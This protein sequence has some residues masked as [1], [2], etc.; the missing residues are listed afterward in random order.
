MLRHL[1]PQIALAS[2]GLVIVGLLLFAVSRQAFGL[3]PARGG[4]LVEAVVGPP[5][6]FNPI[7]ALSDT[8][9]D[10]ARLVFSGLTRVDP[11]GKVLPDLA[12]R[13]S[14]SSDGRVYTFKLRPGV[15][16][17]D[18][19][20]LTAE[21]VVFTASLAAARIPQKAPLA[22]TWEKAR[23]TAVDE[24]TV[25]FELEEPFAPFLYATSLG[26]LPAHLLAGVDARTLAQHR[27]STL[28]PVG[29]G[30]YRVLQPGGISSQ[31]IRL[32]RFD[33][34]WSS[35]GRRPYLDEIV[36]RVHA[37]RAEA[38]ESLVRRN[39]QTMGGV[40]AEAFAALGDEAR[41]YSVTRSGLTLVYWNPANSLLADPEVRR[42]ISLA[43][44]R[45]GLVDEVLSGQ[46]VPA[47][48]PIPPGSWAWDEGLQPAEYSPAKVAAMLDQSSWIDS[49]GD[50]LR[51]REGRNLTFEL[52]TASDPLLVAI[53]NRLSADWRQAGIGATVRVLDQQTAVANLVARAFDA[54]LFSLEQAYYDPDP[55]P[56]WHSSQIARG[57]NYA[58]WSDAVADDLLVQ[59]RQVAP[60]QVDLRRAIY[61]R[62]ARRW[63]DRQPALPLYHPV[64]TYAVVDPNL[65]GLQ[66]PALL[67]EPADRFSTLPTWYL[68]SER[69][70]RGM[71]Q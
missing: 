12:E 36:L 58:G 63:A 20:P 35:D 54:F 37:T 26:I 21:D 53:A 59:A 13:W 64:Y 38:L 31:T 32:Q 66:L 70:V 34:H 51:D 6:T 49:D 43:T 69:V 18:G 46:A 23:A 2:G 68:R 60:D 7:L 39:V 3:R 48:G 17:H 1:R 57:Q 25:R 28:E 8:E 10:V 11:S 33:G 4:T 5:A 19:Q 16:W 9:V 30:P 45:A 22:M 62:F 29:T 40:P 42:A 55:F 14:V 56:L 65:G 52:Q 71:R 24:A 47:V 27:F 44:N 41:L 61:V 15:R 67:V 50:G